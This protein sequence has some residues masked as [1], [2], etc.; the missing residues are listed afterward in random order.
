MVTQVVPSP[1][2]TSH[3]LAREFQAAL[4]KNGAALQPN[5]SSMEGYLAARVVGE[6]LKS[7]AAA[8]RLQRD[9]LV[10]ALE[11]LNGQQVAGFPI[12][13]RPQAGKPGFV[14]L[15]MLTSDGKARV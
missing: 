9:G 12:A 11:A 10:A 6:A 2:K 15:S 4:Q 3:P 8:G 1:F 7:A 5:Y 14:E 13:F